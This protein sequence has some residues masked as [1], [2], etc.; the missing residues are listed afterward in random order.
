MTLRVGLPQHS[1]WPELR[2]ATN[3]GRVV[4]LAVG[5]VLIVAA[6]T[7]AKTLNIYVARRRERCTE[8]LGMMVGMV[9]GMM[10]GLVIGEVVGFL[11]NMFWG[12]LLGLLFAVPLGAWARIGR[13]GGER[14]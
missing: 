12:N 9:A 7:A 5:V 13:S 1:R 8:M 4:T 14:A 6:V 3:G 2:R 11:T 10:T